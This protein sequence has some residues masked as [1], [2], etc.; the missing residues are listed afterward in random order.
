MKQWVYVG[1]ILIGTMC[2]FC[3]YKSDRNDCEVKEAKVTFAENQ[4]EKK[5]DVF[6]NGEL[7]TTF[8]WPD[9]VCK[10]VFYPV[11]TSSGVEITRGFP[12]KPKAGERADHPHQIGI[13]FTYGN[14]NGLDFWGNGSSGLGTRN[15]NGGIIRH[16]K[17]EK[18]KEG[19]REGSFL[20]NESWVDTS[21]VELLNELTEYHFIAKGA[22]RIIDRVTTLTAVENEVQMPDTKEGMFGIRVARQLELPSNG[23]GAFYKEDGTISQIKD[24]LNIGITGNYISSE[25][26]EGEKVWGT[27]AR[28]MNLYGNIENEKVSVVIC[29][30]PKNSNYP[31]YWHARGY[32][33]FAANPLGEKDFTKNMESLNFSILPGI[34][35]IFRYRVIISS[36]EHLQPDSINALAEDFVGRYN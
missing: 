21:D 8:Q 27:R 15:K 3:R 30:H 16:L 36:G 19:M 35:V 25:G 28:W 4:S 32:G 31:T 2:V 7:F 9:N 18:I 11:I 17:I 12:M 1:I 13:W 29:D 22:T 34:P 20:T 6:I 5:M 24:S 14:V 33:L 26:I 23:S 10:P